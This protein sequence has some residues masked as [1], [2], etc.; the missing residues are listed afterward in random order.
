MIPT[1]SSLG[2][3]TCVSTSSNCIIWEGQ[4][5]TCID[6]CNGDTISDVT[7]KL[8]TKLCEFIDTF[9]FSA[10]DL[11]CIFE[12]CEA[13]PEPE[14]TLTNILTLL[15]NKVCA[16]ED[17]I[18]NFDPTP[19]V[20]FPVLDINLKCMAI[21]DGNGNVLNDDTNEEI[22][23]TIIDQVCDTADSVEAA[24]NELDDH[25]NRITTLENVTTDIPQ[26][27]SDCLF[28]G[29]RDIDDAYEALDGDY[30]TFKDSVGSPED[31]GNAIGQQC[32]LPE[33]IGNPSFIVNPVSLAESFQNLWLA[34]C[35]LL[36]RVESIENTCCSPTCDD[37]KIGFRTIF[38]SDGTVTL[39]FNAGSGTTIPTGWEDCGTTLEITDDHGNSTTVGLTLVNNYTSP[40]IDLTGFTRGNTL[41]FTLNV[42]MCNGSYTCQKCVT[43]S[44]VYSGSDCCSICNTGGDDIS[45]VYKILLNPTQS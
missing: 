10:I 15:I 6:L 38:N 8:A 21:T 30:C 26:V 41:L 2:K 1:N 45:I 18:D 40:D 39:E 24:Q 28:V 37:V 34:Y 12:A 43:K 19:T 4:D 29:E 11:K 16:L 22:V 42:K 25:E 23:Q 27:T 14:K 17:L 9:D 7:Y 35:N 32:D 44:V 33:L 3:D 36:A 20:N 13:C 31:I 5:I